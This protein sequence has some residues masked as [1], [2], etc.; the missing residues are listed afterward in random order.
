MRLAPELLLSVTVT[1]KSIICTK[2]HACGLWFN[3]NISSDYYCNTHTTIILD[4]AFL[5]LV[6]QPPGLRC[7]GR[8]HPCLKN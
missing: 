6:K 5:Q 8:F 1:H 4:L 7:T 2:L 3:Y